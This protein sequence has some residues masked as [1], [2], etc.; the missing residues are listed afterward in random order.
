M[1][2]SETWKVAL[3][4]LRSNKFRAFLTTLGI[5]IGSACLV[6]VVTIG[7]TGRQ[8]ILRQIEGIGSN[9]VY[10]Y[11]F[12]PGPQSTRPL[13]DEIN[14]RDLYALKQIP[15]VVRV[16]GTYDLQEPAIINGQ[17]HAIN[18][19]GV[20]EDF[21]AIRNLQL[22]EGRFLD[23]FDM[24][25]RAKAGVVSEELARLLGDGPA[26]GKVL[27]SGTFDLIVVGVFRERVST[28]G[29]SEITPESII[30]PFPLIRYYAGDE[31]LK[32]IYAQAAT[33]ADVPFVTAQVSQ[34][35]SSRHRAGAI[36]KVENLAALLSTARSISTTL[37]LVLLVV[38][39]IALIISGVGIMN[40]M[41]VTVTQRTRE[42]GVRMAL[43][44]KRQIILY[45][46]LIEALLISGTGALLGILIALSI[47]IGL[48]VVTRDI[49]LPISWISVV[50]SFTTSCF[51]GI[52]FALLPARR[53]AA[54]QP[55]E[56]L[57]YE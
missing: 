22:V 34:V 40:I 26:V 5:V 49:A 24:Q 9:I 57:H 7:L 18:V 17:V 51:I 42:I 4:A 3:D 19:V 48:R 37:T 25:S 47:P 54:L 41:L 32:T 20:T 13:A 45:Q 35:L 27:H 55:T 11:H 31:W 56:A 12:S 44:A 16:A 33:A 21:Q 53:A 30:V 6:L 28:F 38:A 39:M 14:L 2:N 46:F 29:Q 8:Y 43:G 23:D 50:V 10:A 36:Y 1:W 52:L 15:G